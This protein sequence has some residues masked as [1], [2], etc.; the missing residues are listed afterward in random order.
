MQYMLLISRTLYMD[1]EHK[2]IYSEYFKHTTDYQCMYGVNTVVLMQVGAF[3][4]VYGIKLPKQ[5][6]VVNEY[7][8]RLFNRDAFKSALSENER[9][10]KYL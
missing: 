10:M 9:E 7:A 2:S 8:S 3:F 1:S 6:E 5:A 4:E